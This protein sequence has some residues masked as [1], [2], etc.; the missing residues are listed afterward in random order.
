MKAIDF[1]NMVVIILVAD[2]SLTSQVSKAWF[3]LAAKWVIVS[4]STVLATGVRG[5]P[6][7]E[8]LILSILFTVT[9]YILLLWSGVQSV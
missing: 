8:G 7:E 1:Q 6:V 2:F 9:L 3:A 4:S 5:H